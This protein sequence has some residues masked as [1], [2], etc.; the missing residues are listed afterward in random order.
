[1]SLPELAARHGDLALGALVFVFGAIVGSFLNVC[2]YRLP[3]GK[4]LVR[5]SQSYCPRCHERIAWHDNIPLVSYFALGRQCRHCGSLISP[6][7]FVVEL[8]TAAAFVVVFR[9]MLARGDAEPTGVLVV[10]LVLTA[11]LIVSS[12]IDLELRIIPDELTI[13]G[14]VA[15]PLASVVVPA[16][17]HHAA[18]GRAPALLGDGRLGALGASL[19]GMAV[20]AGA[21]YASGVFGKLLFRKEAMGLGDVKFM[22]AIGGLLGW[23]LVLLVFFI[24]PVIGSV[25]GLLALLRTRDRH[26]P[27]GPFLSLATFFVMLWGHRILRL[28]IAGFPRP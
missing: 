27:Y 7:Y 12:F 28:L 2:I 15:A 10:Y 3:R 14:M 20:G 1:M 16:L 13:G 4:S 23:K 9:A 21:I 8:L 25:V 17:H 22:A 19:L 26:I 11:G 24:A 6:R 18:Y 5:P